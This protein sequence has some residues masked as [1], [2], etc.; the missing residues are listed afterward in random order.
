MSALLGLETN[1]R[2]NQREMEAVNSNTLKKPNNYKKKKRKTT[3]WKKRVKSSIAGLRG[4]Q[5]SA[6]ADSMHN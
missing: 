4:I 2:K 3:A 5:P 6:D 1:C